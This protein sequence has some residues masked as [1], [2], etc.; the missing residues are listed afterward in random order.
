M[1]KGQN[2]QMNQSVC[3]ILKP[4]GQQNSTVRSVTAGS[5]VLEAERLARN[6]GD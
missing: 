1:Y 2:H 4:K 5:Q 3:W 6:L